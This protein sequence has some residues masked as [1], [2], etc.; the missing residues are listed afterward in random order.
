M[1]RSLPQSDTSYVA[2]DEPAFFSA[3]KDAAVG[4]RLVVYDLNCF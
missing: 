1:P 3:V 4:T 2:N